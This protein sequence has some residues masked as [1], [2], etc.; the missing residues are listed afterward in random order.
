MRKSN[1]FI[2][3]FVFPLLICAQN[4]SIRQ[5]M[6]II[7][8]K[9]DLFFVYDSSL[10][11]E[12]IYS[13][14]SFVGL[15]ADKALESIFKNTP[16][17][18]K[19]RKNNVLLKACKKNSKNEY[20]V[21]GTIVDGDR[22]PLINVSIYDM[23]TQSG[24]LTDERGWYSMFLSEGHHKLK[25]TC[26]G[27][28][29]IIADIDLS[30]NMRRDFVMT[31]E[32]ELPEVMVTGDMNSPLL[33]TQ[34]GKKTLTHNDLNREFSLLSSPDLIKTLQRTSGV[35][36]GVEL[37]SGLFVHGGNCDENM[38]LLDGSSLYQTNHSLGLFS[39]FNTDI[40]KNVDFYKS[41]FPA[42]YS[43]RVS[44]IT[45]IRT[46][47]GNMQNVRG[48]LSFGMIDGRLLV[49]GP[50]WKERTSFCVAMR[51]SWIDLLLKPT[52][53]LLNSSNEDG[54]KYSYGYAFHDINAKITHRMK[55]DGSLWLSVYSGNDCYSIEDNSTW[56]SYVTNTKNE[57]KWGNFNATIGMNLHSG[58]LTETI[59]GVFTYS[60]SLHNYDEEDA[61][62]A[63]NNIVFRNSLDINKNR[64]RLYDMG[65]K[66][67]FTWK[68]ST[69]HTVHFGLGYL[70]HIFNP[71]TITQ[72]FFFNNPD[73]SAD[74]LNNEIINKTASNECSVYFED[75]MRLTSTMSMNVGCSYTN[76][77][78]EKHFYNI[79]DPRIAFKVQVK[80]NLSFKMSYTN[81]SQSIHRIASSFLE[82][83]MDFWIPTTA[84]I[85]PTKSKQVSAG[86]YSTFGKKLTISM[87]GYYKKTSNILQ[88][89]KWMGIQPSA[90]CWD[91]HITEGKGRSWGVELDAE[92]KSNKMSASLAYTL[93]WSERFFP[94]LCNKW[95]YDQ[96]DNRHKINIAF[97]YNF[98]NN[99]SLYT[100]W[101]FH[102]GNKFT[103][104]TSCI[105]MPQMPDESENI[106]NGYVYT[107]PN[108]FKLPA[109]HRLD[110]GMNF[111]HYTKKGKERIWN[112][113]IYNA[114][115]HLNT[116]YVQLKH[117][118]DGSFSAKSKGFVPIIPSISY[119]VK[120]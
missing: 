88:Y 71:Q 51:R 2:L 12:N 79:F 73:G 23:E 41:G 74:S 65:V 36:T 7:Q 100:V 4:I 82:M 104:P 72:S 26:F 75:E 111:K 86:I 80:D 59:A 30:G 48:L 69:F 8:K 55:G 44:S 113:S 27:C 13:D 60:H 54:E 57:F 109:Y 68:P 56:S 93:S 43:G 97:N 76:F 22:E 83:P 24:I 28:K 102:D 110:I 17:K 18:Y 11:I 118:E 77:V 101:T 90:A 16:I 37:A 103:L 29:T 106:E 99:I 92:F 52:C 38:F 119:T 95:F 15:S 50:L 47:D 81:M 10:D 91:K 63:D 98:N 21:N 64:T 35:S 96:F 34:T 20:I 61:Y 33:T 40:I 42:R 39:S 120:F 9:H 45:D 53:S 94:E 78:V 31:N 117:N 46:K 115:C 66:T 62:H 32:I 5:A 112:V 25:I 85:P 1:I 84:K 3:L 14:S 107:E 49:E 19:R 105:P 114:Y 58:K 108:N 6:D 87:E 67:D 70:N 89:N 116:M